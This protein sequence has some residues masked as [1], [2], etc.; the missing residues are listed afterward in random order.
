MRDSWGKGS[1]RVGLTNL[2]PSY[3]NRLEIRESQTPEI[4]RVPSDLHRD[5]SIIFKY[6]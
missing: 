3:A 6:S 2:P 5:C 4:L 1:R